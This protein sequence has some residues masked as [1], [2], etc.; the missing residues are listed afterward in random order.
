M[1]EA[2]LL[3][4]EPLTLKLTIAALWKKEQIDLAELAR[5]RWVEK[6]KYERLSEHFDIGR[7]TVRDY[8]RAIKSYP[9]LAGLKAKP[10]A[11]RGN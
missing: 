6:W 2:I 10:P 5:L 1:V 11:V 9:L 4:P 3:E 7:S 8:I